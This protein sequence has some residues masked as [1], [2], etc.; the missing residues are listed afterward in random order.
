MRRK[1]NRRPRFLDNARSRRRVRK[2]DGMTLGEAPAE[3]A[4]SHAAAGRAL[5]YSDMR[6][7]ILQIAFRDGSCNAA[8]LMTELGLSRGGIQGH[9]R[10][11]VAAGLLIPEQDPNPDRRAGGGSNRLRWHADA[12]AFDAALEE[13]RRSIRGSL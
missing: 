7:R 10:A 12:D 11:L 3:S 8:G 13:Y 4:A 9:V 6:A 5:G 2:N 1:G